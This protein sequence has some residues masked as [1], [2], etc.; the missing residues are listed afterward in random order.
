MSKSSPGKLIIGLLFCLIVS[1]VGN[2]HLFYRAFDYREGANEW[3]DKYTDVVEEYSSLSAYHEANKPLQS[4]IVVDNRIVFYGTQVIERWDV[5]KYFPDYE[6]INRGVNGQWVSGL[7]LRFGQDVVSL[8]PEYVVIEVSSYNL[9]P[10][11]SLEMIQ[12]HVKSM[13]DISRSNGIQPILTTMIPQR[14]GYD[15]FGEYS[16]M[17]TLDRYNIWIADFCRDENIS[18]L[19]M[20]GILSDKDGYLN[21][22]LSFDAVDPNER[23]YEL[24]SKA[25]GQMLIRKK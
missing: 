7:L 15:D 21:N 24:I 3:L 10:R 17:K 11:F 18:C 20:N 6:V 8:K 1:L 2:I 5:G 23:G 19:D 14:S 22:E 12:S 13:A 25:L 9:R 16:V 4:D